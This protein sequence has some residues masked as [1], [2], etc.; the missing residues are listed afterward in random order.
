MNT[1]WPSGPWEDGLSERKRTY[2]TLGESLYD[3][4]LTGGIVPDAARS[5]T[6]VF[7]FGFGSGCRW[8]LE[9]APKLSK[10]E[11]K[12]WAERYAESIIKFCA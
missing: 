11:L 12:K 4:L 5:I 9:G 7:T 10:K 2:K 1:F 8:A 3:A 6:R